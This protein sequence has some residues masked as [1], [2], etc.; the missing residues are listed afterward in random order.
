MYKQAKKIVEMSE[1]LFHNLPEDKIKESL[2]DGL[3]DGT[4]PVSDEE[5][6]K[7]FNELQDI[8]KEYE[9]TQ[10]AD[11]MLKQLNIP[12][13]NGS[14]QSTDLI[15]ILMNEKKLKELLSKINMKA[16]W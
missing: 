9:E 7:L 2:K 1:K 6:D 4:K 5:V 13:K 8:Q 16:F 12:C 10:Q 15:K 3:D 11:A 14:V